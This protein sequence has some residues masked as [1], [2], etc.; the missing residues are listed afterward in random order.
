MNGSAKDRGTINVQRLVRRLEEQV[1][2]N[3]SGNLP[4]TATTGTSSDGLDERRHD[5][6]DNYYRTMA[7]LNVRPS[8]SVC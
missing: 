8:Q 5:Q 1:R 4:E 6:Y 7:T 3:A 2:A